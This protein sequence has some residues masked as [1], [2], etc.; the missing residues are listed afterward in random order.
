MVILLLTE[1]RILLLPLRSA[2]SPPPG[3]CS[4]FVLTSTRLPSVPAAPSPHCSGPPPR[5][6]TAPH[7]RSASHSKYLQRVPLPPTKT[8]AECPLPHVTEPIFGTTPTTKHPRTVRREDALSSLTL[9]LWMTTNRPVPSPV[10]QRA[11]AQPKTSVPHTPFRH[12]GRRTLP[13]QAA[14]PP[15]PPATHSKVFE[16]KGE[17]WR[18]R[19]NFL[20]KVSP[21]PPQSYFL[22]RPNRRTA[23]QRLRRGTVRA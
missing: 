13:K 4:F 22:L 6:R 3:R 17:V 1:N 21:P 11:L 14:A 10:R 8:S 2:P 5:R 15:G 19:G 20:Q 12:A 7:Q 23:F 18:G 16:R 9:I